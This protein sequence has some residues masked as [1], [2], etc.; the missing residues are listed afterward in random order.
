MSIC[1]GMRKTFSTQP[2]GCFTIAA[3]RMRFR[4]ELLRQLRLDLGMTQEEL[5][6]AAGVTVRTYR[7][8]ESGAVNTA[9]TAGFVVRNA[10]RRRFLAQLSRELGIDESDLIAPEPAAEAPDDLPDDLP[11]GLDRPGHG[12]W[13]PRFVHTLQRAR[14]FVGRSQILSQLEAW[15]R[16]PCSGAGITALV[17]IG[18]AGKTA[19]VERLVDDLAARPHGGGLLVWSFFE[20][21]RTE[22]LLSRALE[23]FAP[24]HATTRVSGSAAVEQLERTLALGSRHIV[25]LDGLESV[26]SEG[27]PARAFGELNDPLLRRLLCAFA[28]GLGQSRALV[29]SR[30]ELTDVSAWEGRG[31]HTIRLR[32]LDDDDAAELLHQ[33]GV[34]GDPATMADLV[35]RT[36]GHALSVAMIGSY[37]GAL[38]GGDPTRIAGMSL[39]VAARDD[40][41]ARRLVAVLDAYARALEP[42]QRDLLAR[43]SAFTQGI[44]LAT[45]ERLARADRAIAGRLFGVDPVALRSDL[46]R[47]VRLGVV[48]LSG[49][50]RYSTHPLVRQ[51]FQDRLGRTAFAIAGN[52]APVQ[53]LAGQAMQAPRNTIALNTYEGLIGHL[54]RTDRANEAFAIYSGSMG[55]F[56]NLGLELGEMSRGARIIR[57]FAEGGE[58]A[59]IAPWLP[60]AMRCRLVY[61]WGLYSGALGD[62]PFARRCYQ[63]YLEL[64][65]ASDEQI[66]LATGLRTSAYVARLSGDL[67]KARQFILESIAVAEKSAEDRGLTGNLVRGLALYGAIS[68]DLGD[69]EQARGNFARLVE[70]GNRPIA[71]RSLW[72]AEHWIDLGEL[73]RARTATERNLAVCERWKWA[74]H[75]AHCHA[76]LGRLACLDHDRDAAEQHLAY[77][78]RW[79]EPSGEVEMLL[80]CRELAAQIALLADSSDDER[81]EN[82]A[83]AGLHLARVTGA[84]WFAP[85]FSRLAAQ[86]ALHRGDP[87]RALELL[88]VAV[89]CPRV[90]IRLDALELAS[91]VA[92]SL[93]ALDR[94]R[95]LSSERD[96]VAAT[97]AR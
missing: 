65:R 61:D 12:S 11:E 51:Y 62:L 32:D 53:S 74:G 95:A 63:A 80:R 15:S 79:A 37:V 27:T 47:L 90:W 91:R 89:A 50:S 4:H 52:V 97:L 31:V 43:L 68:H 70:L 42:R 39:A 75:V 93:G 86:S 87:A 20:N 85:S 8:Y 54:L 56:G 94:A 66:G 72:Q 40:A 78:E 36:G 9:K 71:R 35:Q 25:V 84:L 29:T 24:G 33:W 30:F 2:A 55:G 21:P 73:E 67:D 83:L 69:L 14:H 23:Y 16:Q 34:A 41:L 5:A 45:V 77:A 26:Q 44:D 1:E 6:E 3:D 96:A 10:S 19:L 76:V 57:G 28:R 49:Q 46:A 82:D 60:T 38:L 13:Q 18:G 17:G 7:R 58:P 22:E 92:E 59:G 64:V 88:D 48:F 81:A